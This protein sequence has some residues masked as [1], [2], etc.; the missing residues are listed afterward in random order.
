MP[1]TKYTYLFFILL[2]FISISNILIFFD[3]LPFIL[4][5]IT[6]AITAISFLAI[7]YANG[8]IDQKDK[9]ITTIGFIILIP[10]LITEFSVLF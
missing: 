1:K 5:R 9:T 4:W 8:H 6:N 3:L 10:F 2:V 7:S